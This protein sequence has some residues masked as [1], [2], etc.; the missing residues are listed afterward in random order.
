MMLTGRQEGE[1]SRILLAMAA[2]AV[3]GI[4]PAVVAAG[5]RFSAF[6]WWC[7]GSLLFPL[8]M[9]HAVALRLRRTR[10]PRRS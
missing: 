1:A 3:A 2:L 10:G 8:A 9:M 5:R 6:R 7:Y 4:L